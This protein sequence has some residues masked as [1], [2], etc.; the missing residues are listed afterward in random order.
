MEAIAI[1]ENIATAATALLAPY[2][3]EL[4]PNKLKEVLSKEPEQSVRDN[5]VSRKDA[6]SALHVSLP[7][8]DRM[9]S[10]GELARVKVRGRVFVRESSIRAIIEGE[11][12]H[13]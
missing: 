8:L 6:C 1:P 9:L 7:T 3:P 5:L 10:E 11:A 12:A 2:R 13:A 4:T